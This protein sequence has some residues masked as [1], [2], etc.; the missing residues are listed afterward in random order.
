MTA[1]DFLAWER[2]QPEK[3]EFHDGEVF[4][5]AGGSP[6]H[7]VLS[8]SVIAE[9]RSALRGK[10][11]HVLSSDQRVVAL[12]GRRFF[13]P[14]AVAVCGELRFHGEPADVLANPSIVVEVLSPSTEA[15]DRG[16]KWEA[17][18]RIPSLTDYV[19][20]A[21]GTAILEHFAREADGAWRYRLL[22][23]GEVLTLSNGATVAVDAVFEGA[24]EVA[25]G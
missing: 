11:C 20:V 15:Y 8:A 3:H 7:N 17:Y 25:E 23:P 6:R 9:L 12:A 24:F 16:G 21:Q 5:M 1:D 4:A 19:L 10:G 13:Y 2:A 14:D 22:G 18:Q